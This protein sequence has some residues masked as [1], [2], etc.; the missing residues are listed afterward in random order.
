MGLTNRCKLCP[1][2]EG[3]GHNERKDTAGHRIL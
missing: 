3:A 2:Y 1:S